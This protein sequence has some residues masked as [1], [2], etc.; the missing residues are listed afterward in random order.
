MG[1]I[2]LEMRPFAVHGLQIC[3]IGDTA[4]RI[5]PSTPGA[6]SSPEGEAMG[7]VGGGD[8]ETGRPILKP[9][10]RRHRQAVQK[11]GNDW[12]VSGMSTRPPFFANSL[13]LVPGAREGPRDKRHLPN[14]ATPSEEQG[15]IMEFKII[16]RLNHT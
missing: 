8:I 9:T 14:S 1:G 16:K 11:G 13:C 7:V 15:E 12:A 5:T 10:M 4:T 2:V 6:I 3:P